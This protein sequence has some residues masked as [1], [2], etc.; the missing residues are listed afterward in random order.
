MRQGRAPSA[1]AWVVGVQTSPEGASPLLRNVFWVQNGRGL[2]T[3]DRERL[4]GRLHMVSRPTRRFGISAATVAGLLI[5]L[6]P[7]GNPAL[8]HATIA[9]STTGGPPRAASPTSVSVILVDSEERCAVSNAWSTLNADWS[10]YGSTP[11]SI[12]TGGKLCTGHFTLADLN[13]S[14]ADTVVLSDTAWLYQLTPGEIAALQAYAEQG[15]TIIGVANLFARRNRDNNALA[16]LFGLSEQTQWRMAQYRN[17]P[18]SYNLRFKNPDSP[19]LFRC[20]ADPYV[21]SVAPFGE[22][23]ADSH[24]STNDLAGANIVGVDEHGHAVITDFKG[25][26]YT[27]IYI[28]NEA[29]FQSTPADLQFLYNSLTYPS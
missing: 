12:S 7:V 22:K 24:W 5:G 25:L 8:A 21:S 6:L 14:D 26:G 29:E 28:A 15:H 17:G 3:S 27:A 13:A 20:V 9:A 16:P 1:W 10:K 11:L 19:A 18:P 4:N 23:P 2:L